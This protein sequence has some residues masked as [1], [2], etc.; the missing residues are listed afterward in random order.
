LSEV[1]PLQTLNL[2]REAAAERL[3]SR[4]AAL[5]QGGTEITCA[6]GC[7]A[8]CRQLVVVSPL[9]ALGIAACV[10]ANPS[11]AVQAAERI[12]RWH[13]QLEATP[14]L[15]ARLD[16]FTAAHGYVSGEEGGALELAYWQA[17]LPCPFLDN[18]RCA[19][20]PARP[21]ACREHYVISDPARCARDPDAATPAGTR[22]EYRAVAGY[23]GTRC[24]RLEDRLIPLPLALK[25]AQEHRAAA[26]ASAPAS[27]VRLAVEAGQRQARRALAVMMLAQRGIW[28][29]GR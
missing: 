22:L 28:N 16:A 19:I 23:V 20:F 8:C 1:T 7:S 27:E 18:D 15:R 17:Q 12:R 24:F 29:F 26:G 25:Y 4:I 3:A 14:A 21:F 11:L 2:L 10:D 13:E 5:P 9:E 6:A